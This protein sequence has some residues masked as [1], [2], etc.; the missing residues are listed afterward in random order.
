[1]RAHQSLIIVVLGALSAVA[2]PAGSDSAL[3]T[4]DYSGRLT[5]AGQPFS[6]RGNFKFVLLAKDDIRLWAND[7]N[8]PPIENGIP[9][10]SVTIPVQDGFSRV[11]LGD[12]TLGMKALGPGVRRQASQLGIWFDD[13]KHGASF[14]GLFSL[15]PS[16]A[17]TATAPSTG[18]SSPE[19]EAIRAE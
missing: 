18:A 5:V 19:I 6:G 7:N 14:L 9:S 10:N 16:P 11:Q 17:Q 2:A 13:G 1:M 3:E 12:T 15:A 4:I 8:Q